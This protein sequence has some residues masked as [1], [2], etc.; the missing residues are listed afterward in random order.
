MTIA[1]QIPLFLLLILVELNLVLGQGF[2]QKIRGYSHANAGCGVSPLFYHNTNDLAVC[3]VERGA[4]GAFPRYGVK[5]DLMTIWEIGSNDCLRGDGPM[6]LQREA[7][8]CD[9]SSIFEIA[10]RFKVHERDLRFQLGIDK[11]IWHG[12]A[13]GKINKRYCPAFLVLEK[14][15][16]NLLGAPIPV[17]K[18]KK[19]RRNTFFLPGSDI[20]AGNNMIR[21][22][23][24][25]GA[26]DKKRTA[27]NNSDLR[28]DI[29]GSRGNTCKE[30]DCLF[31]LLY[32]FYTD[33]LAIYKRGTKEYDE[34]CKEDRLRQPF[35]PGMPRTLTLEGDGASGLTFEKAVETRDEREKRENRKRP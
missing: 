28:R 18:R 25:A 4:A 12:L 15:H 3:C 10:E 5:H 22:H 23:K 8:K 14:L 19:D 2:D 17:S 33:G 9:G 32:C 20:Q 21:G 34:G 7:C 6:Y 35:P 30:G 13:D 24:L 31:D 16:V 27:R 11:R 1:K 26:V 29:S